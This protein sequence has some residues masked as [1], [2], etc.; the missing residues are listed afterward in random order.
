MRLKTTIVVLILGAIVGVVFSGALA[1]FVQ[2]SNKMEFC[3][4]CHEMESTV[5]QEFKETPHYANA[6]GVR[7]KCSDCHVPHGN[8]IA[9]LATKVLKTKELYY[10][11]VGK[12]D[13]P[14]KF[15]ANRLEMAESV[16]ASMKASDS[17]ECRNCHVREAMLID[18]QRKRAQ[19][20]HR[21]AKDEGKTCIDCHKGIAHKPVHEKETEKEGEESG[22]GSF[23]M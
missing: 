16:W 9:T 11:A 8:W 13:T 4:S 3:I 6:S 15:E 7:A 2:Y 22:E 18:K 21:E 23:T 10:H 14:E 19:V 20:K 1:S 12:L 5:Y 17:R